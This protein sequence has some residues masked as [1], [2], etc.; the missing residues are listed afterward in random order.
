MELP[1]LQPEERVLTTLESDGSRHWIY[2]KLATGR[3]W[4]WRRIVAYSLI[5]IYTLIPFIKIGGKPAILL[6]LA[7]REFTFVGFTF[8]PTDTVLLALLV[9]AT[10]L[11]I[12]FITAIAGRVW[13]GWACPQTV[14]MEFVFRPLERLFT[15]TSGRGGKA[16]KSVAAWRLVAMYFCYFLICLHL[17]NMFLSYFVGVDK[18]HAW[19]WNSTPWQHPSAFAVV[20]V[21]TGLMMFDFCYWREQLCIIGCPYGRFQSVMLDRSS[22]IIG[23][24]ENRGEPRGKGRDRDERGLGSCVDCGLCVDVCPTGIDIR[25]GLQLEC[26]G[27]AQCIDVCDD[28][29]E[30][31]NQPKGLIRYSSQQGLEG[32]PTRIIRPRTII[33]MVVITFLAT[34]F[35]TVLVNKSAFDVTVLRGLG[36]PFLMNEAG[37]IENTLR[38]KIVNRTDAASTYRIEVVEPATAT[39]SSGAE[40]ESVDAAATIVQ[41]VHI[42]VSRDVF[43]SGKVDLKLRIIDDQDRVVEER[44]FMLGP[45]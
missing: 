17:S 1:V 14:Y 8:L 42:H 15:G 40:V 45:L 43:R 12:F 26:I 3:F 44:F 28:V 39:I 33:Y 11:F 31:T 27:C 32:Q 19:I 5:A 37:D 6:D 22:C 2:P 25:Q 13:C 7:N 34:A 16:K 24:D 41:P 21:V 20:A 29:M 38:V 9:V 10:G 18:L 23:Y 36:K 35:V 30:R 4:W